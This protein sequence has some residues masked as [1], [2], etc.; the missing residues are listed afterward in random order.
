M[1]KIRII[2]LVVEV[3]RYVTHAELGHYV[4][5]ALAAPGGCRRPDD[6]LFGGVRVVEMKFRRSANR[7]RSAETV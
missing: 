7:A 5:T 6:P 1:K 3:D 4:V 2:E